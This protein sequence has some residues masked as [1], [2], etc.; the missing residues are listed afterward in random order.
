MRSIRLVKV[1][2]VC[3]ISPGKGPRISVFSPPVY[4]EDFLVGQIRQYRHNCPE[5]A[6]SAEIR[7]PN[8]GG[9]QLPLIRNLERETWPMFCPRTAGSRTLFGCLH[10]DNI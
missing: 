3:N 1:F 7:T 8:I 6:L 5:K 10:Y 9:T 2:T 4:M